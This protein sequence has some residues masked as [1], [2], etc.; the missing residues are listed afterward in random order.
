MFEVEIAPLLHTEIEEIDRN[1]LEVDRAGIKGR[2]PKVE[3]DTDEEMF[4]ED[5][6]ANS[7]YAPHDARRLG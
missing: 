3:L 5:A 4:E 1:L 6:P 2:V 7:P